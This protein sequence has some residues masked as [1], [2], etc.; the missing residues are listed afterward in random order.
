MDLE[1]RIEIEEPS[2][3]DVTSAQRHHVGLSAYQ[4]VYSSPG[5]EEV[6]TPHRVHPSPVL[7]RRYDFNLP[8]KQLTVPA[9]AAV[10]AQI[11]SKRSINDIKKFED[12]QN[13][14]ITKL[15]DMWRRAITANS[16]S[17]FSNSRAG[18]GYTAIISAEQ[19][20]TSIWKTYYS[21]QK[22]PWPYIEGTE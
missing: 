17:K 18:G 21:G 8:A 11:K 10:M 19:R 3:G 9:G 5:H 14:D 20:I 22:G 13:K 15:I 12:E 7:P 1:V 2:Q 16:F 4:V 6:H